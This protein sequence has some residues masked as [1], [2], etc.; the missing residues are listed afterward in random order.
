M[1]A[2]STKSSERE[3]HSSSDGSDRQYSDVSNEGETEKESRER[4]KPDQGSLYRGDSDC[5]RKI[6]S[7]VLKGAQNKTEEEERKHST[8]EQGVVL[9]C[10]LSSTKMKAGSSRSEM[11]S[12]KDEGD[13]NIS[14]SPRGE[15]GGGGGR[16]SRAQASQQEGEG[17]SHLKKGQ[18][19]SGV[20]TPPSPLS[21]HQSQCCPSSNGRRG[22]HHSPT[23]V[24]GS[25]QHSSSCHSMNSSSS[26]TPSSSFHS[27]QGQYSIC[28]SSS[29]SP[30]SSSSST[31]T[32]TARLSASHAP[33]CI[34]GSSP[35]SS[36]SSSSSSSLSSTSTSSC[37]H[38]QQSPSHG[39]LSP[40]SHH[41]GG[42]A[43]H[44]SVSL[45]CAAA[46]SSHHT[47]SSS[48]A[49]PSS[50]RGASG[51]SSPLF[52]CFS[53]SPSSSSSSS[54]TGAH[55]GHSSHTPS[56]V[57]LALSKLNSPP[58]RLSPTALS[59]R[60]FSPSALSS[61][62]L[63]P[64][65]VSPQSMPCPGCPPIPSS[66]PISD[67]E[68]D[69]E[70]PP[71]SFYLHQ[72]GTSTTSTTSSSSQQQQAQQQPFDVLCR[73]PAPPSSHFL[74]PTSSS[75]CSSS[76][77][78]G[79]GLA[80][81]APPGG[82]GG[83]SL[84]PNS[85]AHHPHYHSHSPAPSSPLLLTASTS[86]QFH[87][88]TS[89]H[90]VS[91]SSSTS[92]NSALSTSSCSSSLPPPSSLGVGGGGSLAGAVGSCGHCGCSSDCYIP[93]ASALEASAENTWCT[94]SCHYTSYPRG[95]GGGSGGI[96]IGH[97]AIATGAGVGMCSSHYF[98]GS[99]GCLTP[100]M[101]S[102][103]VHHL[104][105]HLRQRSP[106]KS[107]T[108]GVGTPGHSLSSSQHHPSHPHM[109]TP[110]SPSRG[111]PHSR[112]PPMTCGTGAHSSSP[113]TAGPRGVLSDHPN[114]E[115][116]SSMSLSA[117]QHSH[118]TSSPSSRESEGR[119]G[120]FSS[121]LSKSTSPSASR[122]HSPSKLSL[123]ESAVQSRSSSS[124]ARGS[125]TAGGAGGIS[126]PRGSSGEGSSMSPSSFQKSEN[127]DGVSHKS[128]RAV[129]LQEKDDQKRAHDGLS[130]VD[131]KTEDNRGVENKAA[132]VRGG[133]EG[134]GQSFSVADSRVVES[135]D[136]KKKISVPEEATRRASSPRE[137]P[138]PLDQ[139]LSHARGGLRGGLC[140]L[141]REE[142]PPV[143]K[144]QHRRGG[145]RS[146]D[147]YVT[148]SP[149][150]THPE[151]S[152]RKDEKSAGEPK[153]KDGSSE[154]PAV[155]SSSFSPLSH[156]E[157]HEEGD[158]DFAGVTSLHEKDP[159]C[160]SSELEKE[161]A[162]KMSDAGLREKNRLEEGM[163]EGGRLNDERVYSKTTHSL[164]D[165]G[166]EEERK[167]S[168]LS[169]GETS[170][171]SQKDRSSSF[172]SM[173][174]TD[175]HH[176]EEATHTSF[177]EEKKIS[178]SSMCTDRSSLSV[179]Q[180][181]YGECKQA[182]DVKAS[183]ISLSPSSSSSSRSWAGGLETRHLQQ[184]EEE[185]GGG[186]V[187]SGNERADLSLSHTPH[188]SSSSSSSA[189]VSSLQRHVNPRLD[190]SGGDLLDVGEEIR[191]DVEEKDHL[192]DEEERLQEN[193]ISSFQENR[194]LVVTG[195]SPSR[196]SDLQEKLKKKD[197]H[198]ESSDEHGK[199]KLGMSS[200]LH[201][202][203]DS[204]KLL[205][206]TK[207]EVSS[208]GDAPLPLLSETSIENREEEREVTSGRTREEEG[209][210]NG[211]TARVVQQVVDQRDPAVVDSP[212]AFFRP[213]REDEEE[214][215]TREESRP[216]GEKE[217]DELHLQEG[218]ELHEGNEEDLHSA[219]FNSPLPHQEKKEERAQEAEEEEN[220]NGVITLQKEDRDSEDDKLHL[221]EID[222]KGEKKD[223]SHSIP[224]PSLASSSSSS[225]E[226]DELSSFSSHFHAPPR[227]SSYTDDDS[228]ETVEE[229]EE[230]EDLSLPLSPS[231]SSSSS[232]P[233]DEL[234]YVYIDPHTGH[235]EEFLAYYHRDQNSIDYDG[236]SF[237]S[238]QTWVQWIEAGGGPRSPLT[239]PPPPS[240]LSLNEREEND[241]Q[242]AVHY[243]PH[244]NAHH[245]SS[246]CEEDNEEEEEEKE[247]KGTFKE[248]KD[249]ST[250]MLRVNHGTAITS[251]TRTANT[252]E[253][254]E[255]RREVFES[256][257]EVRRKKN[258]RDDGE[259]EGVLL[260]QRE[261]DSPCIGETCFDE[262][263]V[264]QHSSSLALHREAVVEEEEEEEEENLLLSLKN[265]E[266]EEERSRRRRRPFMFVGGGKEGGGG[267]QG[268]EGGKRGIGE[269]ES[270]HH[271]YLTSSS[272]N[273][274]SD[275]ST[276]SSSSEDDE[277]EEER[278][279]E[280][281]LDRRDF[282]Q[283]SFDPQHYRD[284][285]AS[286]SF[287]FSP[288][289]ISDEH[290]K[291]GI[292]R[293][294]QAKD[295]RLF[296]QEREKKK[297][298]EREEDEGEENDPSLH[299]SPHQ[300]DVHKEEPS[301]DSLFHSVH[302]PDWY[303]SAFPSATVPTSPPPDIEGERKTGASRSKSADGE[304]DYR[305]S[306]RRIRDEEEGPFSHSREKETSAG[307]MKRTEKI[308]ER[309]DRKLHDEGL[310][311]YLSEESIRSSSYDDN[312]R[313]RKREE[314]EAQTCRCEEEEE[315][316]G[317]EREKTAIEDEEEGK[318]KKKWKDQATGRRR[319]RKEEEEEQEESEKKLFFH[320]HE[321]EREGT[322]HKERMNK[323]K[324]R[325]KK[326]A[327]L[328][329]EVKR[330]ISTEEE[331]GKSSSSDH[332]TM[333]FTPSFDSDLSTSPWIAFKEEEEEE[334]K[335]EDENP[336]QDLYHAFFSSSPSPVDEVESD[337][338]FE[339]SE[340]WFSTDI[341]VGQSSLASSSSSSLQ[342]TKKNSPEGRC[343]SPEESSQRDRSLATS[344]FETG[345]A[346]KVIQR[347]SENDMFLME[348]PGASEVLY[349]ADHHNNS[350]K[351]NEAHLTGVLVVEEEDG[352][353]VHTPDLVSNG[354]GSCS[355]EGGEE[356][357][358]TSPL[359]DPFVTSST[360]G[361]ED[362]E[363]T[364]VFLSNFLEEEEE[365]KK[366]K[367]GNELN[368]PPSGTLF[369][370]KTD[371]D[372]TSPGILAS[373]SSPPPH[374]SSSSPPPHLSSS[375]SIAIS[376][377]ITSTF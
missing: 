197:S 328:K 198:E 173:N 151:S 149:G 83:G 213:R 78:Q 294:L 372:L 257:G 348:S 76:S 295:S 84:S 103:H 119:G 287:S 202:E 57:G 113:G 368:S 236:N 259:D 230:D 164:K 101:A 327:E 309:L 14:G 71:S 193:L 94:C 123:P 334:E 280:Q 262:G 37:S 15:G 70:F 373:S 290:V 273:S 82:G 324:T 293:V 133:T 26:T 278:E 36:S 39:S 215:K 167:T 221:D 279:N 130:Q 81:G 345:L 282:P 135:L 318:E 59:P 22:K 143:S 62:S 204:E 177:E 184:E 146:A 188:V 376:S 301:E 73:F 152:S 200:S 41:T 139:I 252:G 180:S 235:R 339:K 86:P 85:H 66:H 92:G 330:E 165:A 312:G 258:R 281:V 311:S 254:E 138:S 154:I 157:R 111:S 356:D 272:S 43:H 1:Q 240:F 27:S 29:S 224:I 153:I 218:R 118:S 8:S 242:Q 363:R 239:P 225:A 192:F 277:E 52:T 329:E 182:P 203:E 61:P 136:K 7:P 331:E 337:Q 88:S 267:K 35:S 217:K 4:K 100:P 208:S 243:H 209:E 319:R 268:R 31:A 144:L 366:K 377:N 176:R 126:S 5:K 89:T 121:P 340:K 148:Y 367:R 69:D 79:N 284:T 189:H 147:S 296:I 291:R 322:T 248:A 346:S 341:C 365:K 246:C 175:D 249:A 65:C 104:L 171:E 369:S 96:D 211:D 116:S 117:A 77:P 371:A 314:E 38:R 159:R 232:R 304:A 234:V 256:T 178:I 263:G 260:L 186:D 49:S 56:T 58:R 375:S 354:N 251:T 229:D 300:R 12:V 129:A 326:E 131:K 321:D 170:E 11:P 87:S 10:S 253:G 115:I 30:R 60:A 226:E 155:S 374:L 231:F 44:A 120:G 55:P 190:N 266:E 255:R 325:N 134:D 307:G 265:E 98:S 358:F 3:E 32:P 124:G 172:S 48:S 54:P 64:S 332:S 195:R 6:S 212:Y 97:Q 179:G 140:S 323:K 9:C 308:L 67:P 166:E 220:E 342:K 355:V 90:T 359:I 91:S 107:G 25:L 238:V 45:P 285:K 132:G 162:R 298:T 299:S 316:E 269:E 261:N 181:S 112:S 102:H 199:E 288:S 142:D 223:V 320:K 361:K 360:P 74:S 17:N 313:Q 244:H 187:S 168:L 241:D 127:D 109:T 289:Y 174:D 275:S 245:S 125:G 128:R 247:E 141:P 222:E 80:T 250:G 63:S 343:D 302:S 158:V 105:H 362:E 210:E 349:K 196:E 357:P 206:A 333:I 336:I 51:S 163:I 194:V 20:H 276:S 270:L 145:S 286:Q 264:A 344:S 335:E 93:T 23:N 72:G 274:S 370:P 305:S 18:G 347:K 207:G 227:Y 33:I 40:S 169:I 46:A 364:T 214:K 219:F 233:I 34:G 95:G 228:E 21:Q 292:Q 110:T 352:R 205:D 53:S 75:S 122:S 185:Q 161:T 216:F 191:L 99:G 137:G 68:L 16:D 350:P 50:T 2:P 24:S 42:G 297:E 310:S 338:V 351:K 201:S 306:R 156:E 13:G 114:A 315:K 237:P 303:T 160:F 28:I 106:G 108:G 271:N 283:H 183:L 150:H 353:G 47:S 317:K 19:C